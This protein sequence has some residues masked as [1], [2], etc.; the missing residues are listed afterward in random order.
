[1]EVLEVSE[2]NSNAD[3]IMYVGFCLSAAGFCI[4]TVGL[5]DKGFKTTEL[6]LFGPTLLVLGVVFVLGGRRRSFSKPQHHLYRRFLL[7]LN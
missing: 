2:S 4:T 7:E 3:V 5:G 1:M 6:R